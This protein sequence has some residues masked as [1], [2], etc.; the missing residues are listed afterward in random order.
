ML[1]LLNLFMPALLNLFA[2]PLTNLFTL[3]LNLFTLPLPNLFTL[4][5]NLSTLPLPQPLHASTSQLLPADTSQCVSN[6]VITDNHPP[7]SLSHAGPGA[8]PNRRG[9]DVPHVQNIIISVP[10][11]S[12]TFLVASSSQLHPIK[13]WPMQ[14]THKKRRASV[15]GKAYIVYQGLKL[16]IHDS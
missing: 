6:L 13:W 2:L 12:A 5:L 9:K 4:A 14:P 11:L 3:A 1:P 8:N 7:H 10:H 16:G 15:Q